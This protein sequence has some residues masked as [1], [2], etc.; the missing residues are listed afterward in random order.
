MP[1]KEVVEDALAFYA[2]L[3]T[4]LEHDAEF[5]VIGGFALGFH[6][7]PHGTRGVDIVPHPSP[8]NIT[9]LWQAL[10]ALDATPVEDADTKS[11]T[12]EG[13]EGGNWASTPGSAVST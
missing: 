12:L 10:E 5:V 4:L 7:A 3:R 8:A 11:F 9:R 6:G 13:L 1:R 2:L